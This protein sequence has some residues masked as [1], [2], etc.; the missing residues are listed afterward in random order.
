MLGCPQ[1]IAKRGNYGAYL[2]QDQDLSLHILSR[3]AKEVDCPVSVKIRIYEDPQ[4]TLDFVQAVEQCGVQMLTVH[5]RTLHEKKQFVREA[6]WTII[7]QI[8]GSVQIPVVANGGISC[9]A[10]VIKCMTE[11]NVNAVMS[12]EALLENPKLFCP[13]GDQAFRDNYLSSQLETVFEYLT[14]LQEYPFPQPFVPVVKA[15]LFKMLYRCLAA[16]KNHDLRLVLGG[17]RDFE[18]MVSVVK[19]VERRVGGYRGKDADAEAM[20]AGYLHSQTWYARY[21]EAGETSTKQ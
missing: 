6:N 13:Q 9:Y 5:G 14:L 20:D 18:S 7:K 15:H 12:S 2:L 17:C 16:P 3:M 19:E 4:A 10:D 11:T 21:H 1:N 8:K